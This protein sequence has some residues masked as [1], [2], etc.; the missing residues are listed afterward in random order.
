MPVILSVP[1][2]CRNVIVTV[3]CEDSAES[4]DDTVAA[5]IDSGQTARFGPPP[6]FGMVG[7]S[8]QGG[9]PA[10]GEAGKAAFAQRAPQVSLSR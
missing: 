9:K 1:T 5:V 6:R 7:H 10:I 3:R 4:L 2:P 8:P